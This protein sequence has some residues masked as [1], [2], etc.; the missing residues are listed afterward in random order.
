MRSA[1]DNDRDGNFR[2][3]LPWQF[4]IFLSH[5]P[6]FGSSFD[7]TVLGPISKRQGQGRA[8]LAGLIADRAEP[9]RQPTR[10][11]AESR[12]APSGWAETSQAATSRA[13]ESRRACESCACEPA[14]AATPTRAAPATT[15][16]AAPLARCGLVRARYRACCRLSWSGQYGQSRRGLQ[17]QQASGPPSR[18]STADVNPAQC[19]NPGLV[20]GGQAA[21]R[22]PTFPPQFIELPAGRLRKPRPPR[23]AGRGLTRI[24]RPRVG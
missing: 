9:S 22:V 21:R 4:T 5:F 3:K 8:G 10:A 15:T 1:S 2:I 13:A 11:R 24:A 18:G 7:G 6:S 23:S 17:C 16:P 20:G 12:R 19:W 14:T